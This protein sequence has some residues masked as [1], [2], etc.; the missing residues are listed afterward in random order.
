[1]MTLAC[2]AAAGLIV[3]MFFNSYALVASC[4]VMAS[5]GIVT[6]ANVGFGQASIQMIFGVGLLQVCY[7]VGLSAS[8]YLCASRASTF[9]T[10]HI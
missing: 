5:A 8:T 6:A 9:P 2:L 4:L 1:M 10:S 7:C 3:G